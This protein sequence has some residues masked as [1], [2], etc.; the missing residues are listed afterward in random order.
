MKVS[1]M[2]CLLAILPF[3]QEY[4][5]TKATSRAKGWVK[6]H[7]GFV[8]IASLLQ[9]ANGVLLLPPSPENLSEQE[10]SV[11]VPSLSP[12][13]FSLRTLERLWGL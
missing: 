1:A 4:P 13:D 6:R 10:K 7:D 3:G 2:L 11:R 9:R 12:C 8:K 5:G